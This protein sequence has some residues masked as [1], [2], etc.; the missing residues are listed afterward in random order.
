M[1]QNIGRFLNLSTTWLVVVTMFVALVATWTIMAEVQG[2]VP[3]YL[4]LSTASGL[5]LSLALNVAWYGPF[6]GVGLTVLQIVASAVVVLVLIIIMARGSRPTFMRPAEGSRYR[7]TEACGPL[8][9]LGPGQNT[10]QD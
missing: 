3:L 4:T 5:L 1:I 10:I 6:R 2:A 8:P 7:P 9:G